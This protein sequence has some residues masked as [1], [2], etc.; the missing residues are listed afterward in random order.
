MKNKKFL[1]IIAVVVMSGLL[2]TAGVMAA[3]PA[4]SAY[5]QFKSLLV[6]DQERIENATVNMAMSIADNG[7]TLIGLDGSIKANELGDKM[8]GTFRISGKTEKSFEIYKDNDDV[9]LHLAGSENWYKTAHKD[10]RSENE[11]EFGRRFGRDGREDAGGNRQFR[12]AVLDTIMGDYK[13]QVS[14]TE[15]NGQCTFSLS[16]D[17]GNMPIL[18]QA[19][20]Q[21]SD[22]RGEKRN[23]NPA[24][25]S[26]LPQELQDAFADIKNCEYDVELVEKKLDSITISITVDEQNRLTAMGMSISCS[27]TDAEGVGHVLDIDFSMNLSEVGT[28]VVDEANPDPAKVTI[29]D[30]KAFENACRERCVRG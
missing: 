4:G 23:D 15:S 2:L 17:E 14:M 24:D 18:L 12:E 5:E 25:L 13:D 6:Q 8:S 9:L 22:D 20:F 11:K 30:C 1:A 28:S 29:I 26:L 3:N 19:A 10:V 27:G 21:L 16:L 7:E